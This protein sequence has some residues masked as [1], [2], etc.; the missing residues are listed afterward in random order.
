MDLTRRM[1]GDPWTRLVS[2]IG[3]GTV[4]VLTLSEEYAA[5]PGAVVGFGAALAIGA[6]DRARQ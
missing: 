2:V 6:Y 3:A 1:T 4:T 5:L